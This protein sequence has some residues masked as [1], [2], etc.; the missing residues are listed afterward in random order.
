M[1]MQLATRNSPLEP[2]LSPFGVGER[3][4]ACPFVFKPLSVPSADCSSFCIRICTVLRAKQ[5]KRVPVS[6][7][8]RTQEDEVSK[9]K[10]IFLYVE[11]FY[12]TF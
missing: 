8:S 10:K 5:V 3:Y 2:Y 7:T 1:N 12:F 9:L 4:T 11:F 6:R